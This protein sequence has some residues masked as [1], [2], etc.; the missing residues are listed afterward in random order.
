LARNGSFLDEFS[1]LLHELKGAVARC[2][3]CCRFFVKGRMPSPLCPT[4]TDTSRDA[5]TLMIVE[6]EVDFETIERSGAYRGRYFIL[7]GTLP[8]LEKEPDKRIRARE[9]EAIVA[10]RAEEKTLKEIIFALSATTEGDHTRHFL[11]VRL[12]TLAEANTIKLSTLGR[13]LS[14]GLE[15]EYSDAETLKNALANRK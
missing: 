13:G 7:G 2:V 12:R 9:L 1:R 3:T 15:L 11:E 10:K 5:N 14:T 6:K 4:C 8:P